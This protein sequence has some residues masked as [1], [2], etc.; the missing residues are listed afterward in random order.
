MKFYWI[1]PNWAQQLKINYPHCGENPLHY[2]HGLF[3]SL[4]RQVCGH[5]IVSPWQVVRMEFR[6]EEEWLYICGNH[7]LTRSEDA[8]CLCG[9]HKIQVRSKVEL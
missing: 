8:G 7:P 5:D 4:W 9:P 1:S 6:W 2:L 3:N